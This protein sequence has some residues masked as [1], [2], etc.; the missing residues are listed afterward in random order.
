MGGHGL[1][2]IGYPEDSS[3]EENVF[4]F[5]PQGIPGPVHPLVMLENHLGD[6]PGEVYVAE[7]V[8]AGFGMVLDQHLR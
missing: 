8:V 1:H 2:D 5:Q 7:D 4:P 6:R 3:F